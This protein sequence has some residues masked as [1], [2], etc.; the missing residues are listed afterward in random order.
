MI[1]QPP[2]DPFVLG[3]LIEAMYDKIKHLHESNKV[4]IADAVGLIN[5]CC[6]MLNMFGTDT[7]GIHCLIDHEE[8][9]VKSALLN[10]RLEF[11]DTSKVH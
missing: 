4:D 6:I 2:N 1:K 7:Q 10:A 5:C 8:A 11:E 3:A 9:A